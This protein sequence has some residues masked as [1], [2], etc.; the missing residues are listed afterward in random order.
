MFGGNA[1]L[2]LYGIINN[3][4]GKFNFEDWRIIGL[5]VF[6]LIYNSLPY[7]YQKKITDYFR[8]LIISKPYTITFDYND[9]KKEFS[10]NYRAL[11]YYIN[12]NCL[13]RET[14]EFK[15]YCDD[16]F[17]QISQNDKFLINEELGIY[18]T[19]FTKTKE[20]K[21][22]YETKYVN[23]TRFNLYSYKTNNKDMLIWI[24]KI[25]KDYKSNTLGLLNEQQTLFEVSW[26]SEERFISTTSLDFFSNINFENNY[27]PFQEKIIRQIDFFENEKG[28]FK[29]K[30]VKRNLNFLFS[31]PPGT[32]KTA[33]IKAIANYTKRHVVIIKLDKD[34]PP[35]QLENVL[36]AKTADIR[37][38]TYDK[39]L[40]VIE[41]IDLVT[42]N[43]KNRDESE[44]DEDRK[45]KKPKN[46]EGDNRV[47]L[48]IL[49]NAMDGFPEA[50]GRMIIMTTNRPETL[51]DA[52][53]RPGRAEHYR[54]ENLTKEEVVKTCKKFWGDKFTYEERHIKDSINKFFTSAE[55]MNLNLSANGKLNKI[56]K[57]LVK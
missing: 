10:E 6:A 11:M 47:G 28:F 27:L 46:K 50:E 22:H 25:S 31:G 34:F 42:Q 24:E 2:I 53:K 29:S 12:K 37:N 32:G 15:N 54:F 4:I 18:G 38:L 51:D 56:K 3:F 45:V 14:R 16:V 44:D 7:F 40:F 49:L 19:I 52:I 21:N 1:D 20:I 55:L 35:S 5:A 41:E 36:K 43:F 23:S 39:L 57:V 33:M 9:E 48:G 13:A 30:G 26:E 8:Y 17:Y